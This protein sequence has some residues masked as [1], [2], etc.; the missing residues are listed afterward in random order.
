MH[1]DTRRS[2]DVDALLNYNTGRVED[3]RATTVWNTATSHWDHQVFLTYTRNPHSNRF[4]DDFTSLPTRV[5]TPDD[6]IAE[7]LSI[8]LEEVFTR[9]RALP[10]AP[11]LNN[12]RVI[13]SQ[14][15]ERDLSLEDRFGFRPRLLNS[16]FLQD[17]QD[18]TGVALAKKLTKQIRDWDILNLYMLSGS[19]TIK[20]MA[21]IRVGDRLH[22][23]TGD[24]RGVDFYVEG[25]TQ[26]FRAFSGWQ[27]SLAVT[28][29]QTHR[30][31]R[32]PL[33]DENGAVAF[34]EVYAMDKVGR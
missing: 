27:T 26:D 20:G 14:E 28:R 19:Y 8:S 10:L 7:S 29:G 1:L 6:V 2:Q 5:I 31:R 32:E 23:Q 15:V 13:V 34:G 11:G 18:A 9:W 25:V 21:Q 22:Y 12:K 33:F 17:M 16:P 4:Y 24:K 30:E 3:N